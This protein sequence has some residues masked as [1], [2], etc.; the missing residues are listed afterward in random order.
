MGEVVCTVLYGEN[1]SRDLVLPDHVPAHL[2]VN[3]IIMALGLSASKDSFFDLL[4]LKN[5]SY[6]R[7]SPSRN[8]QQ[9][10]IL[11]GS[12]LKLVEEI[13]DKNGKGFLTSNEDLKLRL[14][15]NTIIGRLTRDN[16][17]DIDLSLLDTNHVVS[18]RHAVITR[19]SHNYVVKDD[20]SRNGTFINGT[21]IPKEQSVTLHPN[22]QICFGS[23]EKGVVLKFSVV[24][25]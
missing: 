10:Y 4:V 7:I 19:I 22:D 15:E 16:H 13:D 25:N 5:E 17:V 23:I 20:N 6:H 24:L 18:R 2:L 8:L 1:E 11:N 12:V 14:R 9:A 3:S 21:R